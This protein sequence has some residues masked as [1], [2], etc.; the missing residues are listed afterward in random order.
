MK[1]LDIKR[2]RS[3]NEAVN[4]FYPNK[5]GI[6]IMK[7][8]GSILILW[9]AI[10]ALCHVAAANDTLDTI[11]SRKSVRNYTQEG[12]D[13]DTLQVLVKA[14][15]AAPSAMDKRPWSFVVVTKK[16]VLAKLADT[17]AYGQMLKSA[18]AAIVVCGRLDKSLPNVEEG[19]WV[20]DCSAATENILLAAES[21]GLG[22]VWLG[23][24]PSGQRVAG[25]RNVLSIPDQV[26]PLNVISIGHPTGVEKPKD[27]FDPSNM[28]WDKW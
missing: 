11:H 28:H 16:D 1:T 20:Q 27:K 5:G 4:T 3:Y 8:I 18:A 15:M 26:V 12:V 22:A 21:L 13:K 23:V 25:V 14:G 9:M 6:D 10:I 19:F 17:L 24:Y 2:L 7:K